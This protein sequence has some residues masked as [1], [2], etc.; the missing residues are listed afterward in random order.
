[1]C[2]V[3]LGQTSN[4]GSLEC[5][6]YGLYLY[7]MT[8]KEEYL[9]AVSNLISAHGTAV[10]IQNHVNGALE[11]GTWYVYNPSKKPLYTG[12]VSTG[13][14]GNCLRMKGNGSTITMISAVCATDQAFSYCEIV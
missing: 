8:T 3:K 13:G 11:N 5:Q 12:A 4:D 14:Q 9:Q 2:E 6:K 10:G 1:M 7:A